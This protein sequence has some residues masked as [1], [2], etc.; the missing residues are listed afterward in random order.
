MTEKDTPPDVVV[1]AVLYALPDAVQH[2]VDM[3]RTDTEA[4]IHIAKRVA[5]GASWFD[6]FDQTRTSAE[7]F[8]ALAAKDMIRDL[9]KEGLSWDAI[10]KELAQ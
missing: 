10:R 6:I 5:D 3:L 4:K 2:M 9:R 7:K 1:S 8:A